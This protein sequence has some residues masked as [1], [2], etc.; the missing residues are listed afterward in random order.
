LYEDDFE[1]TS[2]IFIIDDGLLCYDFTLYFIK[3]FENNIL[4]LK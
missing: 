4:L 2:L 3:L 1:K